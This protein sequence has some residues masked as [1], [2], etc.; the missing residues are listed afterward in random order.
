MIPNPFDELPIPAPTLA[1][2]RAALLRAIDDGGPR[3]AARWR[4]SLDALDADPD[5]LHLWRLTARRLG[6]PHPID[7]AIAALDGAP[8][9]P[10]PDPLPASLQ[11]SLHHPDTRRALARDLLELPALPPELIFERGLTLGNKPPQE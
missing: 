11:R 7:L 6:P 2:T 1:L 10:A 8:D 3:A 4:P 5:T 9:P